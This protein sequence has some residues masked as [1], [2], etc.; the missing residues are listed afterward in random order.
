[1]NKR[2][3]TA[4]AVLITLSPSLLLAPPASARGPDAFETI[5]FDRSDLHN[6]TALAEIRAELRA[7]AETVCEARELRGMDRVRTERR[8]VEQTLADVNLELDQRIAATRSGAEFALRDTARQ[9]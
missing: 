1:M 6:P 7:A 5:T 9:N 2:T 3:L 8:C 4:V